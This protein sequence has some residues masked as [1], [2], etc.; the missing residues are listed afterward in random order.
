VADGTQRNQLWTKRHSRALEDMVRQ[1][2]M[3]PPAHPLRVLNRIA[4]LGYATKCG[5]LFHPTPAADERVEYM[6][7]WMTSPQGELELDAVMERQVVAV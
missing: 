3:T 7:E 4:E 1:R 2:W 6:R 5:Q